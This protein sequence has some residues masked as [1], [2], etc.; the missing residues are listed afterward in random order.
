M[1]G[2]KEVK[3][4]QQKAQY[5]L[6]GF[7]DDARIKDV[8]ASDTHCTRS[9]EAAVAGHSPPRRLLHKRRGRVHDTATSIARR[10]SGQLQCADRVATTEKCL[11]GLQSAPKRWQEQ[12]ET[13]FKAAGFE[14]GHSEP[15]LR[16][17]DTDEVDLFG[18]D[19]KL[20]RQLVGE[21]WL[22]RA[23][24]CAP[25]QR[26]ASETSTRNHPGVILVA[27]ER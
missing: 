2:G 21:L 17:R 14:T 3:T 19:Q 24:R 5:M 23:E 13:M 26:P 11:C 22:D 20:Q 12:L 1:V 25:S 15:C 16:V 10:D 27:P 4:S 6:C 8:L 18:A 7:Q 9:T